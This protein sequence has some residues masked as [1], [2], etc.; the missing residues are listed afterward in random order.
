MKIYIVA[1]LILSLLS[2]TQNFKKEDSN[3]KAV[4][5]KTVSH[6]YHNEEYIDK[7]GWIRDKD[8]PTVNDPKILKFLSN[9]STIAESF[10]TKNKLLLD[11]VFEEIKARKPANQTLKRDD[12]HY[13]Y[14]SEYKE[15][16]QYL[17]HYFT[18][19]KTG[20]KNILL[21]ERE[22][23]LNKDYYQ[24][25]KFETS[26]DGKYLAWI[27]DAVGHEDGT[28]YIKDLYSNEMIEKIIT[29]TS[30]YLVWDNDSKSIYYIK[31]D[32]KGRDFQIINQDI[33]NL[34][35]EDVVYEES[36]EE[37][38]VEMKYSLSSDVLFVYSESW[39][40]RETHA[41]TKN[42]QG[43]FKT[44]LLVSRNHKK[45]SKL[46]HID[47]NY[48][49]YTNV[50][51]ENFDLVKLPEETNTPTKWAVINQNTA[52]TFLKNVFFFQNYFVILER[53][54]GIDGLR[55]IER[56][57]RKEHHIDF[58]ET[59]I[60]LTFY[61]LSQDT[62]SNTL[63]IRVES[64]LTP[65]AVYDYNMANKELVAINENIIKGYDKS[66]YAQ[67]RLN[68]KS[69]DGAEVPVT[70]IYRKSNRPSKNSPLILYVYGAYGEGIPPEF[71][72][73]AMSA[74][75]RGFTYAIAHVRGGDELG[76]KW[77]SQGKLQHK[78]NTFNDFIS[79]S[80]YLVEQGYVAQGNISAM[81]ESAAGTT[82]GYAINERPE[83]Y[84]S[85][86]VLVPFVDVL[87]SLMDDSLEYTMT[88][89][90]EFGNPV[91]SKNVFDYIKSYSPFDN[92]K[93]QDYP[94]IYVTG[95]IKDPAVGYWEPA[96]WISKI[97]DN[98]TNKSLSLLHIRSGGHIDSGI[99]TV[100]YEFA[101]QISFLLV[102]N[103]KEE[104]I[105]T[106]K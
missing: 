87:N 19:K 63:R 81:G 13:S 26:P 82:I 31:K 61:N 64:N 33:I 1:V 30:E 21:D 98:Q 51:N 43:K 14:E 84:K 85:V 86:T 11:T 104:I 89:W 52:D 55:V 17:T 48:Y 102:T 18:N 23:S 95:G 90:S 60:G 47:G 53:K 74:I 68:V 44:E 105:K 4:N 58:G 67:E 20:I 9:E 100:D 42:K 75:D 106:P 50:F 40:S 70:L 94:N 24:L 56:K 97:R 46:E 2:C 73:F 76:N 32:E 16:A 3:A 72:R 91:Q 92:I 88:D 101:K 57:T 12:E 96:K 93:K 83:L 27:E 15:G 22:R 103:N 41:L 45:V 25:M 39:T 71:P 69:T 35:K 79:V 8:Y 7:Y 36:D 37:Y 54:N 34:L 77:H 99:H 5:K 29:G 6:T 28:L 49:A 62:Q 65:R 66:K 80:Q 59:I 10:F 78:K 38:V